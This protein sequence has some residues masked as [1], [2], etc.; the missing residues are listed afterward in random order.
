MK[1]AVIFDLDG[2]LVD[3]IQD[4]AIC[5]NKILIQLGY[6]EHPEDDYQNFVGDGALMLV[7]NAMPDNCSQD[8]VNEG[9]ELFKNSY[10]NGIHDNSK[11]YDGIYKMLDTIKDT[12]LKLAVLSNKP[13]KFTLQFIEYFFKDYPFIEIHGQ[14]EDVP[15]K[16]DPMGAINISNALCIKP[17]EIIFIG[18]TPTDIKTAKNAGMESVGVTWGYRNVDEL[19]SA[20]ADYIAKDAEHLTQILLENNV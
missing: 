15:K 14:K 19:I 8:L 3:S 2:T 17:N 11:V 1:K 18:D 6:N 5:M 12:D 4:I 9:L 16:P 10:E 13:H 20:N 7:Q